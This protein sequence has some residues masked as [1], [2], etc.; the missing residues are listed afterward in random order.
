M[1]GWGEEAA[2]YGFL[3]GM[4]LMLT[5]P[6]YIALAVVTV[7]QLG[8]V[9]VG[10]ITLL[11]LPVVLML[12]WLIVLLT[13]GTAAERLLGSTWLTAILENVVVIAG[14]ALIGF[15]LIKPL[16]GVLVFTLAALAAF[17]VLY[18]A[19]GSLIPEPS[20]SDDEE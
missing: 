17:L 18:W 20:S 14:M 19:Y 1:R 12:L 16:T 6:V 13:W 8:T 3:L 15:V 9:T 5:A 4:P 10:P 2:G 7:L 11:W